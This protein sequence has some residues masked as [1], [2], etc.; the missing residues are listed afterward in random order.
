[1]AFATEI[2]LLQSEN[3]YR[4][5]MKKTKLGFTLCEI[6]SERVAG[7]VRNG[8]NNFERERERVSCGEME[9][10]EK[11]P[12]SVTDLNFVRLGSENGLTRLDVIV[13]SSPSS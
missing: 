7:K 6:S 8:V 4:V 11:N 5:Y 2:S 1:M 12:K 10:G 13:K 9:Y 3:T